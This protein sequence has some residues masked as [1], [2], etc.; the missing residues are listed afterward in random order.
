[1]TPTEW[2]VPTVVCLL[3][4]CGLLTGRV[5]MLSRRVGRNTAGLAWLNAVT[6]PDDSPDDFAKAMKAADRDT[7]GRPNRLGDEAE[8]LD[9]SNK[10]ENFFEPIS[11]SADSA[12]GHETVFDQAA[13]AIDEIG[14]DLAR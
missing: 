4:V 10:S 5:V 9:D 3:I 8:D 2:I 1:M 11:W 6:S 7:R 13:E 12:S 14:E